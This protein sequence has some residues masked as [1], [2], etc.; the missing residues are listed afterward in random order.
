MSDS[1]SAGLI[2]IRALSAAQR[3]VHLILA[4]HYL[5]VLTCPVSFFALRPVSA[6]GIYPLATHTNRLPTGP[7]YRLVLAYFFTTIC[8]S[9][10][11]Y[12]PFSRLI[13]A[14]SPEGGT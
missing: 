10:F 7:V 4:H 14:P 2:F 13:L 3:G 11:S 5:I 6:I 12:S 8:F 9:R 1:S